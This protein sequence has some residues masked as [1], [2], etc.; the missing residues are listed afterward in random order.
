MSKRTKKSD[1][2]ILPGGKWTPHDLRRSGATLMGN[3]GIRPDIIE[4]CLNHVE[5]NKMMRIYQRQS[6]QK[7][8]A[9]A[10]VIIGEKLAAIHQSLD[11]EGHTPKEAA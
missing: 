8:Q 4:K 3:S 5:Q 7:E 10:W 1:S 2:L 6:L 11:A 9:E